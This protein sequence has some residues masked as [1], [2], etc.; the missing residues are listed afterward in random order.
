MKYQ[1]TQLTKADYNEAMLFLSMAYNGIEDIDDLPEQMPVVFR[2]T[3]EQMNCHYAIKIDGKIRSMLGIYPC[4]MVASNDKLKLAQIGSMATESAYRGQKMM[5]TLLSFAV[6]KIKKE[7]FDLAY[8]VG[9]KSLFSNHGFERMGSKIHFWTYPSNLKHCNINQENLSFEHPDEIDLETAKFLNGLYQK[10]TTY[11]NRE[12]K[13]FWSICKTGRCK[14]YL[15]KKDGKIVGYFVVD[16]NGEII[17]EIV[18]ESV[19]MNLSMQKEFLKVGFDI[20][21]PSTERE[22]SREL[23]NTSQGISLIDNDNWKI[24]NYAQ[25]LTLF[26]KMKNAISKLSY[27]ELDLEIEEVGSFRFKVTQGEISCQ[28]V[29]EKSSNKITSKKFCNLAFGLSAYYSVEALTNELQILQQW[30]PLPLSLCCQ[31]FVVVYQKPPVKLQ[32]P[33]K[34]CGE[35]RCDSENLVRKIILDDENLFYWRS[36][37]SMSQLEPVSQTELSLVGD[38]DFLLTFDFTSQTKSFTLKNGDNEPVIFN[39]LT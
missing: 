4:E 10:Q 32:E 11:I 1:I 31:N 33:E 27:G 26:L 36:E 9:D 22:L 13:D 12:D 28:Q 18:A 25:V 39:Q 24:F 35:Y 14:P 30:F 29:T 2:P 17:K 15:A 3:E 38:T 23:L 34:F 19:S 20:Y 5:T 7:Q 21:L 8:A 16:K 37:T 6:E